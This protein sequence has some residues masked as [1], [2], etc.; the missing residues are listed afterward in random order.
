MQ[1]QKMAAHRSACCIAN[2]LQ[3]NM[4]VIGWGLLWTM[5][6]VCVC[7][8]VSD[9][10]ISSVCVMRWQ[11]RVAPP[12][13]IVHI[14]ARGVEAPFA[15]LVTHHNLRRISNGRGKR[16]VLWHEHKTSGGHGKQD[17]RKTRNGWGRQG[18]RRRR[19]GRGKRASRRT[20]N[21]RGNLA[22]RRTSSGRGKRVPRIISSVQGKHVVLWFQSKTSDGWCK[23]ALKRTSNM[24][25]K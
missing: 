25:S 8:C 4:D 17:L 9:T 7:V 13:F 19:S 22:L 1:K 5:V 10:L 11:C 18:P 6:C 23:P 16:V 2:I 12:T 14:K 20:S 3:H 24:Q 15:P 21:G